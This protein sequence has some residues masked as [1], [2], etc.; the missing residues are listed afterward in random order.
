MV[1]FIKGRAFEFQDVET[2]AGDLKAVK[3]WMRETGCVPEEAC[4]ACGFIP[5]KGQLIGL[6]KEHSNI[7]QSGIWY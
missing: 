2:Q 3:Q 7:T 6:Y 4:R 1:R 5:T